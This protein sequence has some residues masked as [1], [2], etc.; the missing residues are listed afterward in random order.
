MEYNM[1]TV[2]QKRS[3]IPAPFDAEDAQPYIFIS[4]AH[5][6]S[7]LV[8]PVITKIYEAGYRVWYDEGIEINSDYN[9]V[10]AK[11]IKESALFLMFV[12]RNAC[13]SKY[14]MGNELH[15]ANRVK[16]D[17]QMRLCFLERDVE[18]PEGADMVL[19]GVDNPKYECVG[20]DTILEDLRGVEGLE[21]V[22]GKRKAAGKTKPVEAG[23]VT[24]NEEGDEYSFEQIPGGVRLTKYNGSAEEVV[25]PARYKG[26][27][28]LEL[29]CTF[30]SNKIVRSVVISHGLRNLGQSTFGDCTSLTQIT[31]PD[32]VT[33]IGDWAFDGCTSL[34]QIT[35]PDSVTDIGDGAFY[36]CTSLT[37]ITIPDSVTNIGDW[38]FNG[39]TSLT[40]ITI[41]DSVTGIGNSAFGGCTSLTITCAGQSFACEYAEANKIPFVLEE[42]PA[43]SAR[44]QREIPFISDDEAPFVYCSYAHADMD[45]VYPLMTR[46][47]DMG[48]SIRYDE[49]DRDHYECAG[50]IQSCAYFLAF[51][52]PDYAASSVNELRL[53]DP[54]KR[55][56]WWLERCELPDGLD[57]QQG[58][59]QG[60]CSWEHTE[61][62]IIRTIANVLSKGGCRGHYV[63]SIPDFESRPT[64]DGYILTKYTGSS[65]TVNIEPEYFG[66]PVIAIDDSAFSDCTLL[67]QITIPDS[68]TSIGR[69]AFYH[70]TALTHITIPDSVTSIGDR[71]FS[72]CTSLTHITIPDSV[73]SI[74]G[75]AF[76]GC[77]SLTQ[78]TIP[79]RVTSIGNGAFSD[80][81]SLT[82]IT[83]P[84]SVIG[85]GDRTFRG[86][87]ALT[88]VAI[89]DS[90][91]SIG[92]SAFDRCTSLTQITIPDRVTSIGRSAFYHCTSLTQIA[93]PGGV[94][95]IGDSAFEG[96][97]SLTQITIPDSVTDIGDGAFSGCTTLTQITI[98][99]SVT[100]IGKSAFSDCTSLTQITIPDS[101]TNIGDLAFYGCTSLTQITIPDSVTSIGKS[102]FRR[103]TS[104]TQITIPDSV[105]SIGDWAFSDCTSLTQITIPDSVTSIGK[106]AFYGCTS[107]TQVIIPDGV[108]SIG[109]RAFEGCDNLT[110]RCSESSYAWQYCEEKKIPHEPITASVSE[111]AASEAESAAELTEQATALQDELSAAAAKSE[112][113]AGKPARRS[114]AWLI[115]VVILLAALAAAAGLQ[116]SGLVDILGLLGL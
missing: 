1:D 76:S 15:Y 31:I 53:S 60:Q 97:T 71:A 102:A 111:T 34:T 9:D 80:C 48:Y 93:I 91:T 8:Y 17:V 100:S 83:I 116:L 19:G 113:S 98:P 75:S 62:D 4:Y 84:D 79:D 33:S 14:V 38:A 77:T 39:C 69:S 46:L 112:T 44:R 26:Q 103:C 63:P 67:T 23:E 110:V 41:P 56:L 90:V 82:Q 20:D 43:S 24:T 58:S 25:V 45:K 47:H 85:I 66:K 55:I 2:L 30:E 95:S 78:I 40:Q 115:P 29:S 32:S 74:G 51:I 52:T 50:E 7:A 28:V 81:T 37:Q 94:T 10:I 27:R 86:C 107:L 18:L 54:Q 92:D 21:P 106:S 64:A 68:V 42:L 73:T 6:D 88:Q 49:L 96:C 16:D 5:A 13:A 72:G 114:K 101:V 36:S 35:I 3:D 61:E 109:D 105:T 57:L 87:T 12:S 65:R 99:D 104:L 11:H 108:T 59:I 89:P 22:A 70:C